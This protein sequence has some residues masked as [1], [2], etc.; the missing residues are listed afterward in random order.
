MLQLFRI[1]LFAR[2][3]GVGGLDLTLEVFPNGNS[4]MDAGSSW[5]GAQGILIS[6]LE[7]DLIAN[8]ILEF[9]G[10]TNLLQVFKAFG[11]EVRSHF[12]PRV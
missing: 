2:G 7:P 5:Q 3:F 9:G 6:L 10:S 12:G 1:R 8:T 4:G 11:V